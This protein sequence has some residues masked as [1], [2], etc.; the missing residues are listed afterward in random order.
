VWQQFLRACR[1]E[2]LGERSTQ[3]RAGTIRSDQALVRNLEVVIAA[4]LR[5]VKLLG[6]QICVHECVGESDLH[7]CLFG[8]I[9]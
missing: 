7:A 3:Q 1:S 2:V 8:R 4:R 9:Q 6:A 5:K